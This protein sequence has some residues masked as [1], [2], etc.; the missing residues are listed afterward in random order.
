MSVSTEFAH[1]IAEIR[2]QLRL[3]KDGDV[4]EKVGSGAYSATR[5]EKIEKIFDDMINRLDKGLPSES[6]SA[7]NEIFKKE[8]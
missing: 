7:M 2:Y 8:D 4:Y 3:I 1:E 6:S 5:V